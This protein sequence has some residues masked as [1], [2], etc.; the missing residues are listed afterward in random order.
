MSHRPDHRPLS[1]PTS[2]RFE[3]ET[4][5]TLQEVA[6]RRGVAVAVVVR[7]LVEHGLSAA[8]E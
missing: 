8:E 1:K 5:A 3:V 6:A 7:G 2:V 4:I